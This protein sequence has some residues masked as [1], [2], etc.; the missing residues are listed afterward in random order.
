MGIRDKALKS[1]ERQ[2]KRG[3][4]V[5]GHDGNP[6]LRKMMEDWGKGYTQDAK[7]R[8]MRQFIADFLAQL[9]EGNSKSIED[10]INLLH[11]MSNR[12]R[13]RTKYITAIACAYQWGYDAHKNGKHVDIAA[14]AKAAGENAVEK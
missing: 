13:F 14:M 6:D 5:P 8:G 4:A 2:V 7:G 11:G 9:P 1:V 3:K 12:T 10:D